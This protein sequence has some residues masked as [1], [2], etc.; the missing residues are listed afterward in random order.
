VPGD[1]EATVE[2]AIQDPTEIPG[3]LSNLVYNVLDPNLGSGLL[4]NLARDIAKPFFYL[5]S[6]IGESA[7]G[8]Q[9]G[10]AWNLYN[11]FVDTVSNLLSN[12]PAPITPTPFPSAAAAAS[13]TPVA[14]AVKVKD[15]G[16]TEDST[17]ASSADPTDDAKAGEQAAET[18]KAHAQVRPS[19]KAVAPERKS[20]KQSQAGK[21]DGGSTGGHGRSARPGKSNSG[22]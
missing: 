3:L 12:L 2:S 5:P 20:A 13:A 4:G 11:G 9:D 21:S 22:A 19:R 16:A 10:L 7:P 17:T 6:P 15:A 18:S 14:A 1:L 8:A